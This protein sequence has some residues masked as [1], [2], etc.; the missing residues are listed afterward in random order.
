MSRLAHDRIHDGH[1]RGAQQRGQGTHAD[2]RHAVGDVV[3]G[4]VL[5]VKVA[6]EAGDV[7]GKGVEQLG[8]RRMHVE[9]VLPGAKRQLQLQRPAQ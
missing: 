3:V 2:V 4:D 6:L 5:E 9:V 1:G 8:E 7:A